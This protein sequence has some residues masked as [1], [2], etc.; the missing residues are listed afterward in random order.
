[1]HGTVRLSGRAH[2]VDVFVQ[3]RHSLTCASFVRVELGK[4]LNSRLRGLV[5][6]L[7][8]L[9]S[10]LARTKASALCSC[11]IL[12]ASPANANGTSAGVVQ[13]RRS[14]MELQKFFAAV[15]FRNDAQKQSCCRAWCYRSDNANVATRAKHIGK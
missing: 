8:T 4:A 13:L 3:P 11:E 2:D 10:V 7:A 14:N 5:Q 6:V 9:H 15:H 12:T 1:M